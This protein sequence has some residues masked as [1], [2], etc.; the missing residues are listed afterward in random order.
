[1]RKI[2]G[3]VLTGVIGVA[4][5][6]G[7]GIWQVQRLH[8]KETLLEAI[9]ARI[10]AS[11]VELPLDPDPLRDRYLAVTVAGSFLPG[12]IHVLTSTAD[13]TPGYYVVAPFEARGRKILV[14]RGVIPIEAAGE[15]RPAGP[16][17]VTGNL[18]WPDEKDLFTPEPD[19]KADIWFARD[20]PAMADRL[21]TE[22]VMVV[23]RNDTGAGIVPQPVGV[24]GIPNNHLNYAITWF[25]LAAIW[26]GMTVLL[27]WRIRRRSQ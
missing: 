21:E 25:S 22:P 4:I 5:L 8:W 13:G 2:V 20:V 27:V 18:Q 15:A 14:E 9:S 10:G 6:L 26:A 24:E 1:M 16:A 19:L 12:E 17:E 7:L 3:P 23:A 11:P